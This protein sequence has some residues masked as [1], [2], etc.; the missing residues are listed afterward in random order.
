[1]E[2]LRLVH[3]KQLSY[4]EGLEKLKRIY[5]KKCDMDIDIKGIFDPTQILE[6]EIEEF[7]NTDVLRRFTN[8]RSLKISLES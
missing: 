4:F 3:V 2:T 7:K 1:M 8:L 5:I 6:L